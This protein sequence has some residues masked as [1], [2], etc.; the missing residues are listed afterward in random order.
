M[1][2]STGDKGIFLLS[3]FL[4]I[5]ALFVIKGIVDSQRRFVRK[6]NY[7]KIEIERAESEEERKRWERRLRQLYLNRIPIFNK[8]NW[9]AIKGF[10]HSLKKIFRKKNKDNEEEHHHHHHSD[11]HHSDHHH[12]DHHHSDHHHSDHHHNDHHGEHHGEHYHHSDDQT[13]S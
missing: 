3:V 8:K 7:Y 6:R 12:S 13:D 11:H 2:T 1:R 5:L 9:Y 4:L 10:F